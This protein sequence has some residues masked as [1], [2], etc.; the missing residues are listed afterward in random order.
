LSRLCA[1]TSDPRTQLEAEAYSNWMEGNLSLEKENQQQAY[2]KFLRAKNL[3]KKLAKSLSGE[4]RNLCVERVQQL[5]PRL[6]YCQYILN[7][8]SGKGDEIQKP[9]MEDD[10]EV[11]MEAEDEVE[12]EST[13]QTGTDDL[14]K[15]KLEAVMAETIKKEAKI[16][17]NVTW[18]G[19]KIPVDNPKLKVLMLK[20]QDLGK[21]L[22]QTLDQE[23]DNKEKKEKKKKQKTTR[24][25]IMM[26]M[27]KHF[28]YFKIYLPHKMTLSS[29]YARSRKH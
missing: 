10:M 29:F 23:S 27:T 7:R 2:N 24:K 9:K 21:N 19:R 15:A 18:Q 20:A 1:T 14:L 17:D 6:R 8:K 25:M 22:R 12:R 26:R 11:D 3:Y 4:S 28:H 13:E 16:F 5:E